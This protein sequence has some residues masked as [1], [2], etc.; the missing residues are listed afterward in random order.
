MKNKKIRA[1]AI[2]ATLIM[3]LFTAAGC[4]TAT[5]SDTTDAVTSATQAKTGLST[6]DT[7]SKTDSDYFTDRDSDPSYDESKA[8]AITLSGTSA[9]AGNDSVKIDGT[10]V[11]ITDEGIYEINGTLSDGQIIVNAEDADKIQLV[12]NG[13]TIKNDDSACILC[14][15]ADKVFIT[16]ADGTENS[17]SDTGT[18]FTQTDTDST[19]DGVI[20][21][22]CDLTLNGTGKLTV[23]A[24]YKHAVVTKDDMA[25]TGGKYTITSVG[26]AFAANNSIRISDGTFTV[27][28]TDD[29]F[30]VSNADT[31]DIGFMYICGGTFTIKTDDDALHCTS[32]MIIDGGTMD[33]TAAEGIEGT[34]IT[35][36]DG[37]ITISASDDGINASA[38]S[39]FYD[40]EVIINGGTITITMGQGDTDGVDANGSITVN[41]GTVT[42]TGQ[43][44]F[45]YDETGK[46]NGGTVTVNG[47]VITEMTNQMMGGGGG[48]MGGGKGDR[49]GSAPADGEAPSMPADG[50]MSRPSRSDGSATQSSSSG[51]ANVNIADDVETAAT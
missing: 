1:I 42:I 10:T 29:A 36:N 37:K 40:P 49:G 44:A 46:I 48:M 45:D 32:Q 33:I 20:F 30:H 23:K 21:A 8:V 18:E 11:T 4:G 9:T 27:N 14:K 15:N 39:T 22:R 3:I 16:L 34:S 41:G 43:S 28:S 51:S 6:S 17:L 26:K 5:S 38:K 31:K 7:S 47:E 25:I 2:A 13:V 19:V 12:L 50:D 35:I 24:S